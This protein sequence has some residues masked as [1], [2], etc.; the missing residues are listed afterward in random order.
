MNY[1]PLIS[2]E[3]D[4]CFKL[5]QV[6]PETLH[7]TKT[8]SAQHKILPLTRTRLEQRLKCSGDYIHG[9]VPEVCRI[10]AKLLSD[11]FS[12]RI[13]QQ[14]LGHMENRTHTLIMR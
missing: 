8:E 11:S 7:G 9:F 5:H 4:K 14:K 12:R 2:E 1:M 6:L 3:K 13:K 10:G